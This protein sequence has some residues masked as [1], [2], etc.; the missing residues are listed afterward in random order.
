MPEKKEPSQV[1]FTIQLNL[2]WN[3]PFI[4]LGSILWIPWPNKTL[5]YRW[6][7]K[8][9]SCSS[10]YSF[11]GE[12]NSVFPLFVTFKPNP[13]DPMFIPLTVSL[14]YWGCPSCVPASTYYEAVFIRVGII[15]LAFG[16][17]FKFICGQTGKWNHYL[18]FSSLCKW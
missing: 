1:Y 7:L 8:N 2:G 4:C 17:K 13:T 10:S 18:Y 14:D 16:L 3:V 5:I 11:L 12:G 9:A 15:R 6:V